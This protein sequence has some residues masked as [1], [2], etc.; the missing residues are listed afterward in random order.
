MQGRSSDQLDQ[1][2][3][4]LLSRGRDLVEGVAGARPGSRAAAKAGT[5]EGERRNGWRND[6]DGLGRWVENRLDRL[7]DDG[8]SDWREPWQEDGRP[9]ELHSPEAS[10]FQSSMPPARLTPMRADSLRPNREG[11]APGR[12]RLDA[13]SRRGQG[14]LDATAAEAAHLCRAA[15]EPAAL[16]PPP[17]KP[18]P[19]QFEQSEDGWPD[20]ALFSVPRWSRPIRSASVGEG[21][22]PAAE[23]SAPL[24]R[25]DLQP[26]AETD[27]QPRP[28]PRSSR[29][30]SA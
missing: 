1:R 20:E 7:L 29:R 8:E 14:T 16:M 3:D 4:R 27:F 18:S 19:G 2:L 17:A 10:S 9:A 23:G 13:I 12:R 21:M 6:L 26:D 24:R 28:L 5:R 22:A 25:G 11:R 30:R 15:Q